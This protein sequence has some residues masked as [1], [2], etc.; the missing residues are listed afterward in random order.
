MRY[1]AVIFDLDG[2]LLDTL[3]DL[4][5]ALNFALKKRGLPERTTDEVRRFIGN[6]ARSLI[7]R[8]LPSGASEEEIASAI[9]QFKEYYNAHL[10]V[11]ST[12]YPGIKDMLS[13]LNE[14]G[15]KVGINS[16][17]YDLAVKNLCEHHFHG[18]YLCA[19]GE[20]SERPRKPDP[21][22]A[23]LIASD[24]G[25]RPD[26]MLYIGDSN[27]DIRTAKNAGMTP[28]WVSWGFRSKED[29]GDEIPQLCFDDAR[30]LAE[31]I[32]G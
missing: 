3:G 23:L 13:A 15:I 1:K 25:C 2:T 12:A 22:A 32:I 4:R 26:E 16:N 28:V 18:L 5:N 6:G 21:A 9:S 7:V 17:K 14:A 19:V 20:S 29:M 27:V 30:S 11:E 31:F 10:N 24:F 8:S